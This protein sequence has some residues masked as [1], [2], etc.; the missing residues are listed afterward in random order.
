M[1]T[2]RET[3]RVVRSWL[4]EGVTALPER[5]LDVVLDQV[6]A[7]PQR[8]SW[9]PAR[10]S[11]VNTYLKFVGA[12]AALL[13]VVLVGSSFLPGTGIGGPASPLPTA[14]PGPT[15]I[16]L[17]TDDSAAL[18]AGDYVIAAP[19][20]MRITVS[21]P[22]G[23]HGHV[24]GPYY[25]DLWTT[26]PNGGSLYFVRPSVIAIDPCDIT[27]GFAD[28]GGE[29]VAD[30]VSALRNM[31]GITISNVA[32]TT[33]AGYRGTTLIVSAP[34]VLDQCT[35]PADGY[36]IWRN[37]LQGESP[38]F[39]AGES[40]SFSILDVAG[41]RLVIANQDAN[42]SASLRAQTQAILDSIRIAPAP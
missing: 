39:S 18:A 17:S 41:T 31:P 1:S 10:R 30:L 24:A 6:P 32:S 11:P 29:S 26:G 9:W 22:A 36:T 37:P 20:P 42:S 23:W 13:V 21:L 35:L 12:A 28:I 16:P 5:V 38:N 15:A 7:T 34:A 33:I 2:D 27:K 14:S 3:T 25:A 4:E 19:F 40:I 8:R